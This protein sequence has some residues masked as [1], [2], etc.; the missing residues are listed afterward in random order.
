[1]DSKL[2]DHARVLETDSRISCKFREWNVAD[3]GFEVKNE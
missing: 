2:L 1:M 3:Y